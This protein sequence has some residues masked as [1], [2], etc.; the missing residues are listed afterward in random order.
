MV[1]L[2]GVPESPTI[3]ARRRIEFADPA[4]P[5]S[6]Q[7]YHAAARLQLK[8]AEKLVKDCAGSSMR[9]AKD[10]VE[11]AIADAKRQGFQVSTSGVLTGSAKPIP[12]L[13]KVLVSHPLLHT[14]EGDLF[15]NV[16]IAACESCGLS[17]LAVKEK[18]LTDRCAAELGIPAA[19]VQ[20]HVLSM[21]K[22][23]GPPWRQ[24]EKLAS[25]VAWMALAVERR[26]GAAY[27]AGVRS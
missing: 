12:E 14:A 17:V 10:A 18:E 2:A 11:I 25:R 22:L 5:G 15:R 16:I 8:D 13:E 21:G 3:A 27:G 23:I 4:I 1:I 20:Q 26:P 9:F 6:K 24:D 7:P 19:V